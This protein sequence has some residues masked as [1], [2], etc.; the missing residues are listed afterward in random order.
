AASEQAGLQGRVA[1]GRPAVLRGKPK[2]VTACVSRTNVQSKLVI[3]TSVNCRQGRLRRVGVMKKGSWLD[4]A[5][6]VFMPACILLMWVALWF[7]RALGQ[8]AQ[9]YIA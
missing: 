5:L 3:M 1:T 7:A 2:R 6:V 8:N 4:T 9:G